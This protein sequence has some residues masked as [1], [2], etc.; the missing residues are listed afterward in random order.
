VRLRREKN[1][2]Y[3]QFTTSNAENTKTA[4]SRNQMLYSIEI[5]FPFCHGSGVVG[6]EWWS[7]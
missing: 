6:G 2:E 4:Y 7:L 1:R 3:F 5:L